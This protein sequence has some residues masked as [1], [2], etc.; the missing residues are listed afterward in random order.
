MRHMV[1]GW[2]RLVQIL[3]LLSLLFSPFGGYRQVYASATLPQA[4]VT[5]RDLDAWDTT[6]I[7]YVSDDL[8]ENWRMEF[9]EY[10]QFVVTA[11]PL[12]GDLIP[13][14][15][16]LDADG[17]ELTR[18]TGT[19]TSV[20]PPGQYSLLVQPQSGGGFYTLKLQDI[21]STQ[22]NITAIASPSTV[23][24]GAMTAVVVDLHQ[25]PAGG[26]TSAEFTCT[27]DPDAVQVLNILPGTVFGIDPVT[28]VPGPQDGRFIFAIAGSQGR[29]ATVS[30]TV[31]TILARTL[32]AGETSIDCTARVSSGDNL[33]T[34]IESAPASLTVLANTPTPEPQHCDQVQ[35]IADVNFPDGSIF[36]PGE[37]FTKTWRI[38]NIGSCAWTTAYQL[39]FFEGE[40]MGSAASAFFPASVQPGQVANVSLNL[41]APAAPG[42]YRGYWMLKNANGALFGIGP[43][44][45]HAWWLEIRV[46][47]P[48]VTPGGP[49][50]TPSATVTPT[51]VPLACDKA[52]FIADITVPPGT[53]MSPGAAFRKTWRLKNI[54]TCIWTTSYRL[55]LLGGDQMGAPSSVRLPVSVAPGEMVDLSLDMTAPTSPGTYHGDWILQNDTGHPFGIGP[56]GNQSWTVQIVVPGSS[57]TP[58]P[59]LT[60]TP[61][62]PTHSPT[63]SITPGGPTATPIP[64]VAY[65]FA[66]NMCAAI[67][68][69]GAGQLPCPGVDGNVNGFVFRVGSPELE[70]GAIDPRPALLTSPQNVSNGYIQGFYPPFRVQSGDRFRALLSCEFGATSCYAAFRLDYQVG[71]DPIRTFW[72]PFLERYDDRVYT[73]DI[74]L[75]ALAGRDVKFILTVL[76]A[77]DAAG[78]RL[79]WVGPVI[80]RPSAGSTPVASVTAM[81]GESATPTFTPSP[82]ASYVPTEVFDGLISGQVL[83]SR[84]V[85]IHVYDEANALVTTSSLNMDGSFTLPISPGRYSVLATAPGFLSA[86]GNAIITNGNTVILPSIQLLPGDIDNNNTIDALDALTIGMS[87]HQSVPTAADLNDDGIINVLDLELLAKNYRRTGPLDWQ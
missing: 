84:D 73:V 87:Y 21:T 32:Q 22:P 77:G 9:S 20:Q 48:T 57:L 25:L 28:V 14:L 19:L 29:K 26:Y 76:A 78:D 56:L 12:L 42:S 71:S 3:V 59:T 69:S 72:G 82:T 75:S 44:A 5:E 31:F 39:V 52:E 30:D 68:F 45:S 36:A 74:D 33:L 83:A 46:V 85:T 60:F 35:F 2:K 4:S 54:G 8:H 15:I 81:P 7:G 50:L 37:S 10:H 67:W 17:H 27:Y 6:Y 24:A 34:E 47:A 86:L 16:L 62:P 40:Q 11:T 13:L 61:G 64:N 18:A 51:L 49:T 65:D 80:H 38:K 63:P 43:Q 41:T 55:A 70:T 66:A 53:V 79:L 1:V 58:S 23:P